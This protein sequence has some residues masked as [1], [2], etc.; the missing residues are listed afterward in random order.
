MSESREMSQATD[1]FAAAV[2]EF[3]R[4]VERLRTRTRPREPM[5]EEEADRF[6]NEAA[7]ECRRKTTRGAG[8]FDRDR[9]PLTDRE[10]EEWT[11]RRDERRGREGY[12]TIRA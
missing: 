8:G 3:A 6:G 1:H 4:Q 2:E 10:V 9:G 5:C 12:R 7:H 11:R